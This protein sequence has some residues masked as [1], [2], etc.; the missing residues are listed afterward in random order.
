MNIVTVLHYLRP[1]EQWVLRGD[2]YD[3]LEWMDTTPK[4]TLEELEAAWPAAQVAE[5]NAAAVAN[6]RSAFQLEADPLF[7]GWQRGEGI[8]QTWLDKVAEIRA[9]YPYV[10]P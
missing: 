5:A 8:E 2:S 3:G 7:F 10:E 9:R 1:G 6:R 4:P